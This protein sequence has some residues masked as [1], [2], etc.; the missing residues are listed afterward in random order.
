VTCD[1][2]RRKKVQSRVLTD[3]P[4]KD[5]IEQVAL[6]RATVKKKYFKGAKNYGNKI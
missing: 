5:C 3:S 2:R 1:R 4:I 6:A